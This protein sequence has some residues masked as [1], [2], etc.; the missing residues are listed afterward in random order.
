MYDIFYAELKKKSSID[1]FEFGRDLLTTSSPVKVR[2]TRKHSSGGERSACKFVSGE[3]TLV[4]ALQ[5]IV[6]LIHLKSIT[7]SLE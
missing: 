5:S 6:T 1:D 7:I 3:E 2:V 4:N